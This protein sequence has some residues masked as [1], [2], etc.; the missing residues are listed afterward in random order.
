MPRSF[1]TVSG[2]PCSSKVITPS[3]EFVST[4]V[5]PE[6]TILFPPGDDHALPSHVNAVA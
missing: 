5:V 2:R 6:C 3:T 1:W 4:Q